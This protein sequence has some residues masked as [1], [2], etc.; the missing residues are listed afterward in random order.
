MIDSPFIRLSAEAR[1]PYQQNTE[2][3]LALL[4]EF[5]FD[6]FEIHD[7]I[8]NAF[9]HASDINEDLLKEVDKKLNPFCIIP[10]K[11]EIIEKQNWN[12]EWEKQFFDP[13]TVDETVHIRAPFHPKGSEIP[14]CITIEPR[15]SFGTGHHRTTQMMISLMLQQKAKFK[16][17]HVLDMGCGTGVLGIFAEKMGASDVLGIDNESW[18]AENATDNAKANGCSK[19]TAEFGDA[20]LLKPM[21][22][23]CFDAVLANIHLNVLMTD[24]KSYL[25]VL[26]NEGLLFVSGFYTQDLPI[27]RQYFSGQGAVYIAE[28]NLEGWCAAVFR[29]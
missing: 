19:F 3:I 9:A 13:I 7:N 29:K 5:P 1:Q 25:R 26:K 12:A 23:G 20:D 6:T 17:S 4:S 11:T 16:N 10:Y 27:L 18:A 15:M 8:V 21:S 22:D 14:Y 28:T 2:I 24:G